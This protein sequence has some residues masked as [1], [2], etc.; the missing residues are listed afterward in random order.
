MHLIFHGKTKR[1]HGFSNL[2]RSFVYN[3]GGYNYCALCQIFRQFGCHAQE[4]HPLQCLLRPAVYPPSTRGTSFSRSETAHDAMDPTPLSFI[5]SRATRTATDRCRRQNSAPH[6]ALPH[7]SSVFRS[8][9]PNPAYGLHALY[10]SPAVLHITALF[11]GV[12]VPKAIPGSIVITISSGCA[13][14]VSHSGTTTRHRP[15]LTGL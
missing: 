3:T 11:R 9:F 6:R 4:S 15:I 13:S 12:P 14:Y 5:F 10:I 7:R 2:L 1:D 8:P